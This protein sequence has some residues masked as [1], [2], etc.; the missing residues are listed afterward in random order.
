MRRQMLD[1]V[2]EPLN[3]VACAVE[4]GAEADRLPTIAFRWDVGPRTLFVDECPDPAGIVA[5]ISKEHGAR[6]KT[7]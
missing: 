7:A 3:A 1:F 2:E 5:S 4:V 6:S